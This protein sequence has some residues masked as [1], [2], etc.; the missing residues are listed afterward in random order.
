MLLLLLLPPF[1]GEMDEGENMN[2]GSGKKE[3]KEQGGIVGLSLY[4]QLKLERARRK[5]AG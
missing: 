5:K 2:C 1:H 3:K 4:C